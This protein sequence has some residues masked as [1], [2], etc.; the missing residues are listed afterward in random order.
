MGDVFP[1]RFGQF[2]RGL[3][4]PGAIRGTVLIGGG[5]TPTGGDG[6]VP[7]TAGQVVALIGHVRS[8]ALGVHMMAQNPQRSRDLLPSCR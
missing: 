7:S 2:C 4:F 1:G 8:F 6:P 3:R 5:C